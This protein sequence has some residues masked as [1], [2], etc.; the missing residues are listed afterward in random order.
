[1]AINAEF[2]S[3]STDQVAAFAELARQGSLR[4]AAELLCISEQGLRNRLLALEKR[5]GIQLYHKRRGMRRTTPLTSQG[6]QFLPHARA[7][8]E[9]SRELCELFDVS[10]QQREV[11]VVASQY[12]TAY[13]LIDAVRRFHAAAPHIRIRLGTRT[14]QEVET[15]LLADP[16]IDL[17]V[18]APLEASPDLDYRHL[19][20]MPWS[21]IAPVGHPLLRRRNLKL[22]DLVDEPLILF[23]RGSTGRQH[24]VDA[25]HRAELSPRVEM[26]T[27]NTEIIVRMVEA[28]LGISLVPLLASGIVTRGRRIG[29]RSLGNCI[30]PIDSGILLRR[31]EPPLPAARQ[32][33]DFVQR[34]FKKRAAAIAPSLS[35]R[36]PG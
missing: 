22:D 1:M 28:G 7:F 6:R 34:R 35:G 32:F 29:V 4:R 19:F 36:G 24:V 31:G 27:T 23:E 10:T 21:L 20:S 26:E 5:L 33:I 18:A 11:R 16:E 15:E 17:G 12:L 2:P 3:L 14:E 30:R 9:R 25:F 13:V 8:L